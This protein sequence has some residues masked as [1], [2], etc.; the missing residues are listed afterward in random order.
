MNCP[1]CLSSQ[2][3]KYDED[4]FRSYFLCLECSLVFVPREKILSFSDEAQRYEAHE[5]DEADDS[6]RKYL[7]ETAEAAISRLAPGAQGLDFG[8]G[9]TTLMAKIFKSFGFS[10][11]T[12][13]LYFHPKEEIWNKKYDFIVLS[14]VIEHLKDPREVM[15]KLCGLLNPRGQFFIKT[16]L[17][18]PD[19]FTFTT[20]FYK[21]D[22][23]HVQFFD[24]NS[25]CKLGEFLNMK[26]PE[27]L[28]APDLFGF[29]VDN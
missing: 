16:K 5:N 22:Q 9:K 13:D 2:N 20:W 1:I 27:K 25:L 15:Q 3:T 26:G 7:S 10:V 12:Y 23:T 4:K 17:Y 19:P 11:D 14:E 29:K 21:R 18:P 6:Y 28:P 8:S 24:Y